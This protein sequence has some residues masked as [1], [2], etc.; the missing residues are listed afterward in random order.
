MLWNLPDILLKP[1]SDYADLVPSVIWGWLSLFLSWD[2]HQEKKNSNPEVYEAVK[3]LP[4]E[5]L[6]ALI[7]IGLGKTVEITL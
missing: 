7:K 4:R 3:Y 2:E 1:A 5:A 6:E